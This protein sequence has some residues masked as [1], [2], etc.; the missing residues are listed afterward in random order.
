LCFILVFLPSRNIHTRQKFSNFL[1]I[2][3]GV[4]QSSNEI[5][6][7]KSIKGFCQEQSL[8]IKTLSLQSPSKAVTEPV[9]T[10]LACCQFVK[11][12]QSICTH[13]HICI[14]LMLLSIFTK[15]HFKASLNRI[16]HL[17]HGDTL[18]PSLQLYPKIQSK[19]SLLSKSSHL[20]S[21]ITSPKIFH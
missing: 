3:K 9:C 4:P 12:P 7:S 13:M 16:Q 10:F 5:R 20:I 15:F 14:I 11:V 2:K 21:T 19:T 6:L 1:H 17:I 8:V 18:S